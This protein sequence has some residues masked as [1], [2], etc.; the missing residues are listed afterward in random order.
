MKKTS[1]LIMALTPLVIAGCM[2]PYPPTL[3]PD[4]TIRV[5]S[6]P[7]GDIAVP[8][9][10]PSWATATADPYDNQPP[11]QYGCATARNLALMVEKPGD[12]VHG[13]ELGAQRGVTAVGAIRRY[14]NNQTRGLIY[15]AA[16]P[17]TSVEVTSASTATSSMT[18]D[19]PQGGS[20]S[21][22]A[23]ATAGP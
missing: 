18:G 10:C 20:S 6:S 11:P 13:R 22:G 3:K 14:D 16:S 21:G 9:E 12:L 5:I 7:K 23:S 17:G 19:M 2:D 1:L 4:Y 15:P 8:P